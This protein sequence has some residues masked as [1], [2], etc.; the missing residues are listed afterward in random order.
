MI[1]WYVHHQGRG[2]VQRLRAV[3]PWLAAPVV[4]FSSLAEPAEAI[5]TGAGPVRWVRLP[6]DWEPEPGVPEPSAADPTAGGALHWAPLGHV[7]NRDRLRVIAEWAGRLD[8]MVTDVSA[9]VAIFSR[10]LGL[11]TVVVTQPGARTDAPHET[12]YRAATAIL[13]PFPDPAAVGWAEREDPRTLGAADASLGPHPAP[14]TLAFAG[15]TVFTGGVSLVESEDSRGAPSAAAASPG[16]TLATAPSPGRLSS[17]VGPSIEAHAPEGGLD[18]LV[19]GSRGGSLA[20]MR[21]VEQAAAATGRRWRAVGLPGAEWSSSVPAL[22]RA[23][24]VVVLNAG[25]G[26]V[27]DAAALRVPAVVLAQERAFGEQ[28]AT[29]AMLGALGIPTAHGWPAAD[30]WPALLASAERAGGGAWSAW[31]ADGGARRAAH[32]I[33]DTLLSH[34][35]PQADRAHET[36]SAAG[37]GSHA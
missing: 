37:T 27:A 15:K 19:V 35:R 32:V 18:V 26:S 29:A 28:D 10:L 20:T 23:A 7:G 21:D 5:S 2:H 12:A 30:E 14:H 13:A 9:E 17:G 6:G 36:H 31:R 8:G 34:D 33:Q 25:L 22:M 4:V 16:A 24:A 11:R 3:A 1:G